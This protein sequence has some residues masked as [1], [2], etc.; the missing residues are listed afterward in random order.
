MNMRL[1]FGIEMNQRLDLQSAHPGRILFSR[2]QIAKMPLM[3]VSVD[4][5]FIN[6]MGKVDDKA[7]STGTPPILELAW[8]LNE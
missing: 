8:K 5:E 2:D 6:G 3:G 7:F 1:R 4:T